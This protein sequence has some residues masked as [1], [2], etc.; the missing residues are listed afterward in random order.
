M[1]LSG[2]FSFCFVRFSLQWDVHRDAQR[3]LNIK[4]H[5]H[6]PRN[7]HVPPLFNNEW[8]TRVPWVYEAPWR[9]K[10]KA[11]VIY[12]HCHPKEVLFCINSSLSVQKSFKFATVVICP[13]QHDQSQQLLLLHWNHHFCRRKQSK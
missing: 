1:S 3:I 10:L 7:K 6:M 5:F 8:L 4:K 11:H 12:L 2:N 9:L 13:S